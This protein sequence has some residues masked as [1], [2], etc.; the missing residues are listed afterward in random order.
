MRSKPLKGPQRP[1]RLVDFEWF[2][3]AF[4]LSKTQ[5][6]YTLPGLEVACR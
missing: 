1:K 5:A 6:A 3:D 2:V 4:E